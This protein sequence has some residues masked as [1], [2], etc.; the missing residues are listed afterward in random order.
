MKIRYL[1]TMIGLR[2]ASNANIWAEGGVIEGIVRCGKEAVEYAKVGI[3]KPGKGAITDGTGH[4]ELKNV[5]PGRHELQITCIDYQTHKENFTIAPND[6]KTF[7]IEMTADAYSVDEV[8]V[9]GTM[10]AVSRT[11]SPVPVEVVTPL[12]FRK[13][14]TPSLFEAIGMVNGVKPQINCNV[15]NT[16]DIHINGM[17]G[18]YTMIL[19]DGMPIVSA[20]SGVYGLSGIPNSLVER[21]EVVKGPASSLY[22]SEAMG[23][24]INVITKDVGKAPRLNM[25]I[26]ATNWLEYNIDGAIS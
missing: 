13:N 2:L 20:L 8:V 14:P 4:F 15:C 18:P 24:I 9:T 1:I 26:F 17:E 6:R 23:G 12:L 10:R 7:D 22:G 16:G 3:P 19:I 11:Q 5:P 25:D 21:I